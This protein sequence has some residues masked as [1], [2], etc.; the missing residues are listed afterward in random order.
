MGS[1]NKNNHL[2]LKTTSCLITHGDYSGYLKHAR[3]DPPEIHPLEGG[4][5]Q[6]TVVNL[7]S[8][9]ALGRLFSDGGCK[10]FANDNAVKSGGWCYKL[11]SPLMG[12]F[13][14]PEFRFVKMSLQATPKELLAAGN[15]SNIDI[16][17]PEFVGGTTDGWNSVYY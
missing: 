6:P 3:M 2:T 13:G 1:M 14:D 16:I 4:C 8:S 17:F 11:T 10:L 12:Q 9:D 7:S 15:Y 5:A